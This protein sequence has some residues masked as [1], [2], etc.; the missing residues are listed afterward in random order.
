M[1]HCQNWVWSLCSLP[2]SV[3]MDNVG[4]IFLSQNSTTGQQTKH[5]DI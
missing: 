2:I 5:I 1:L 4:E 3:H